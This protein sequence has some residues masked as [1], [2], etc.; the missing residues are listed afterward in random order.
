MAKDCTAGARLGR[1]CSTST[2]TV[3]SNYEMLPQLVL[4]HCQR[5]RSKLY[6]YT[7][8]DTEHKHTADKPNKA[9]FSKLEKEQADTKICN[10]ST[11]HATC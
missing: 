9:L 5:L 4:K 11:K 8:A 10:P 3:H 7:Y 6:T 2:E 1:T